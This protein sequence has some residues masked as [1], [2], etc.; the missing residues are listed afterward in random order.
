MVG[1]GLTPRQE[2]G[3]EAKSKRFAMRE[4]RRKLRSSGAGLEIFSDSQGPRDSRQEAS[5]SRPIVLGRLSWAERVT[6][7]LVSKRSC[8]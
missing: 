5:D 1:R 3:A 7:R 4:L 6:T 8:T 2:A